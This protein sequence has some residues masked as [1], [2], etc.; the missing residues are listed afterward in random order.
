MFK[1]LLL[2]MAAL[3]A[4]QFANAQSADEVIGKYLQAIGGK[5]K[6]AGITSVKLENTVSIMGGESAATVTVL[7]GKGFKSEGDFNGSPVVQ[8]LT[9]KDGWAIN[10]MGG[11]GAQPIPEELYKNSRDQIYI[12]PLLDYASREA[13]AELKGKEKINGADAYKII[14]TNKDGSATSYFFDA[15]NYYLVQTV[16]QGE[17]MGNTIDITTSFSDFKATDNGIVWPNATDTNLGGSFSFTTKLNK[18][19]WNPGVDMAI[20]VSK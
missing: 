13:K 7:N 15:N 8:V 9:D 5:E 1:R 2:A 3:A 18:V 11:G 4:I 12:F 19:T 10:P 20:F 14:V 17:M 6:L 16:K